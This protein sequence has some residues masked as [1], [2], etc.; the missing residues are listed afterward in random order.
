MAMH[1]GE[2]VVA[3]HAAN[4]LPGEQAI[5]IQLLDLDRSKQV[6]AA[7]RLTLSRKAILS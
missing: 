2:L 1:G 6:I 3:Y 4:P 7:E 5:A